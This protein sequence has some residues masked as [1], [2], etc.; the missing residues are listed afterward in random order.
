MCVYC[1]ETQH[2]TLR[3]LTRCKLLKQRKQHLDTPERVQCT[4][5]LP[6]GNCLNSI[7]ED[8]V[9]AV[10]KVVVQGVLGNLIGGNLRSGGRW[11]L[12]KMV[13]VI[14]CFLA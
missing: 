10:Y 12:V 9:G 2:M 4:L 11:L 3:T 6:G 7:Q 5:Y 8:G 13:Q 14:Q 1:Y